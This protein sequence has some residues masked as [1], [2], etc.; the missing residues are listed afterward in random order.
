MTRWRIASWRG[1]AVG[2]RGAFLQPQDL[3]GHRGGE[4]FAPA[5]PW[6]RLVVEQQHRPRGV[7]LH[8]AGLDV[9]FE[10]QDDSFVAE[11]DAE[12]LKSPVPAAGLRQDVVELVAVDGG[13][14]T[15]RRPERGLAPSRA[16][17]VVE[18]PPV[19]D[20][21]AQL[22]DSGRNRVLLEVVLLAVDAP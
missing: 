16:V 14:V 4:L 17:I 10:V 8:T 13:G 2:A 6:Q 18:H 9:R 21:I 20:R 3:G 22:H 12:V 11:A 19:R 1:T 7:A 15:G 5:S